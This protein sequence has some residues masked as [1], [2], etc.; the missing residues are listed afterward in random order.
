[1]LG[2]NF[3]LRHSG[4]LMRYPPEET[5]EKHARILEQA[6]VLFRERG[7]SGVSVSEIMKAT[8]LTHGAF[9]NHFESK[10]DL[11][12]K[13][14]ADASAK[15]LSSMS[16]GASAGQS[17]AQFVDEYLSEQHRDDRGNGCLMAALA[18][19][20]AREPAAQCA[21]TRHVEGMAAGFTEPLVKAK[22]KNAR[23]Q[24]IHMLSSIVGAIVLARAV[25]NPELSEEILRETRAALD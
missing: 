15:A 23:R 16:D 19:E 1:M 24:A 10:E 25:N 2:V 12:A 14:L 22:K 9:Y 3:F 7:F 17:M 11:V 8:G 4:G 13:S 21:F 5:A 6:S 20:I 18:S